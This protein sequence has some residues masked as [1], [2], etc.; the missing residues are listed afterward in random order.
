[1]CGLAL[2]GEYFMKSEL[3][4][5]NM[6][7]PAPSPTHPRFVSYFVSIFIVPVL[8]YF[9][10]FLVVRMP[11]Y[12]KW[13]A[14]PDF[15]ALEFGFKATGQNADVVIF[16]DSAANHGIDPSQMSAALGL[17]V[18]NLPND[19]SV[20][21]DI[22]EFSLR[23]Y[24]LSDKPP[25]LIVFYL[26]PWNFDYG[27]YH[28]EA[29]GSYNGIEMMLRYGTGRQVFAAIKSRPEDFLLFPLMF[30]RTNASLSLFGGREARHHEAQ[31]LVATN[32]HADTPPAPH[33]DA[34]CQIPASLISEVGG[35]WIRHA[36]AEFNT[37]QTRVMVYIAPIPGCVNAQAVVDRAR[38]IL[39]APPPRVLPA[40]MVQQDQYYAHVFSDGVPVATQY[41][42]DA[43]RPLLTADGGQ[44]PQ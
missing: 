34:T 2:P 3:K 43:V 30:Y 20:L 28:L 32:G 12:A 36:I 29:G 17:K 27:N 13:N 15:Q 37:A 8:L 31:R 1:M 26:A 19:L 5:V 4:E 10:P 38:S 14:V 42:I 21:R 22:N 11:S 16:G 40:P 24:L 18:L 6:Q 39:P 44:A 35:D 9:P 23:H 33:L 7:T 41:L 25:K